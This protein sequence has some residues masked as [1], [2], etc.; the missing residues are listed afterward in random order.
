M[1]PIHDAS[2]FGTV[3]LASMSFGITS[4]E[5]RQSAK[6]QVPKKIHDSIHSNGWHIYIKTKQNQTQGWF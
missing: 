4:L 5:L 2:Y 1:Q 3:R 6:E